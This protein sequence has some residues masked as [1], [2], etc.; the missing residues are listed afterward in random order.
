MVCYRPRSRRSRARKTTL[1]MTGPKVQLAPSRA[2]RRKD[3]NHKGD[4]R[5]RDTGDAKSCST[6]S[7][8]RDRSG[9]STQSRLP[10][11]PRFRRKRSFP[12][13]NAATTIV[14]VVSIK[15]EGLPCEARLSRQ[16]GN[17]EEVGVE[18]VKPGKD[19]RQA[20]GDL[21]PSLRTPQAGAAFEPAHRRRTKDD[22][23][24]AANT[25]S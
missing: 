9:L 21:Q 11:F 3:E 4:F 1:G 5:R 7:W 14:A 10:H 24:G 2:R 15:V 19:Q 25:E 8:S 23:D 6:V 16:P 22:R 12:R 18:Q 20:A 17:K 13:A